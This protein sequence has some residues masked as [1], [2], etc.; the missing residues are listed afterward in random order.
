MSD[1][2]NQQSALAFAAFIDAISTRSGRKSF[3]NDPEGSLPNWEQ[4]PS[5]VFGFL[6]ALSMEELTLLSSLSETMIKAGL[7]TTV[8]DSNATL[9]HL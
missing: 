8:G 6:K 7:S 2:E 4:L 3:V 1:E 9:A 5:E